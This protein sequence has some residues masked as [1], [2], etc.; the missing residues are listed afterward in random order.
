[1]FGEKRETTIKLYFY[2]EDILATLDSGTSQMF[3]YRNFSGKHQKIRKL[4]YNSQNP[5]SF[6]TTG[7]GGSRALADPQALANPDQSQPMAGPKANLV[8]PFQS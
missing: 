6:K 2:G 1:M 5:E 8:A 7:T 3:H 4:R